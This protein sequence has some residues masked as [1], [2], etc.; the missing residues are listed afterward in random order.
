MDILSNLTYN[1]LQE[2]VNRLETA[3]SQLLE[4]LQVLEEEQHELILTREMM[5]KTIEEIAPKE[6]KLMERVFSKAKDIWT[7]FWKK[8]TASE[9]KDE[10]SKIMK[11]LSD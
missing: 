7:E 1:E 10:W 2:N 6:E 3:K 11:E 5:V 4:L 8:D 9:D